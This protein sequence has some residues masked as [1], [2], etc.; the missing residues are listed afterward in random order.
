MANYLGLRP[1]F[2]VSIDGCNWDQVLAITER[3]LG[4][5]PSR[6]FRV[7]QYDDYKREVGIDT[8]DFSMEEVIQYVSAT[9]AQKNVGKIVS[10]LER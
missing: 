2:V 8:R 5:I 1:K 9:Y 7:F 10:E 6:E 4:K 3:A